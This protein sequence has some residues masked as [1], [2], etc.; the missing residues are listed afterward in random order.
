M[1]C[2]VL[3]YYSIYILILIPIVI[4][5]GNKESVRLYDIT[6]IYGSIT[7]IYGMYVCTRIREYILSR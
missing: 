5:L 3:Y 7:T 2:V 6:T 1:L 4:R